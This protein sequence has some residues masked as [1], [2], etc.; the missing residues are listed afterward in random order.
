MN[1]NL[2]L[3]DKIITYLDNKIRFSLKINPIYVL[4]LADQLLRICLNELVR[5]VEKEFT[6]I[7]RIWSWCGMSGNI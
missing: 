6:L 7:S 4:F 1:Q 5:K 3:K 2:N